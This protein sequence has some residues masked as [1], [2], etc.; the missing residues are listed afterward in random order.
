MT[1]TVSY[2]LLSKSGDAKLWREAPTE[3]AKQL[4]ISTRKCVMNKEV[5]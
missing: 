1:T 4:D 3:V 5:R 2:E